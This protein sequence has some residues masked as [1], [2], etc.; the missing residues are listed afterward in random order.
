MGTPEPDLVR[1]QQAV[2]EAWDAA[3][4]AQAENPKA[5]TPEW[6]RWQDLIDAAVAAHEAYMAAHNKR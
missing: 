2:R 3:N 4:R 5:G 6:R 1:L